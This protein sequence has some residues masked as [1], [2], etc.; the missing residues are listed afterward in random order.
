MSEGEGENARILLRR[1]SLNDRAA[2]LVTFPIAYPIA[3]MPGVRP[4]MTPDEQAAKTD[5][6]FLG[7][8]RPVRAPHGPS[9]WGGS[10]SGLCPAVSLSEHLTS[11]IPS[12]RSPLLPSCCSRLRAT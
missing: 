7:A 9:M 6:V 8:F 10:L 4:G 1:N 11:C 2:A 5:I 3:L 12:L